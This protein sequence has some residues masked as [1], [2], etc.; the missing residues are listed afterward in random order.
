MC[1]GPFGLPID[2]HDSPISPESREP[3]TDGADALEGYGAMPP[4]DPEALG[5]RVRER[6]LELGFSQARVAERAGKIGDVGISD[7]TVSAVERGG[8]GISRV[9]CLLLAR[10]LEMPA[11]ELLRLA[12]LPARQDDKPQGKWTF[13]EFVKQDMN[14]DEDG[15]RLML[16][17]YRT[18][19]GNRR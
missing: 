5:R 8:R 14:L 13:E 1:T 12:G 9:K 10:G 2:D 18:I 4:H 19:T 16:Y 11:D 17:L 7:K 6:R 3:F 15:K